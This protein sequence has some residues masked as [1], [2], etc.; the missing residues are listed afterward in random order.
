MT[1]YEQLL[2]DLS[3]AEQQLGE[4][5]A[6][7]KNETAMF[8]DS[9]PGAQLQISELQSF[10]ADLREAVER[11][12]DRPRQTVADMPAMYIETDAD[13]DDDIPF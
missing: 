8:G 3:Q 6:E 7:H 9:W 1:T 5:I 13:L 4:T 10:V 12:P 2:E 11:H